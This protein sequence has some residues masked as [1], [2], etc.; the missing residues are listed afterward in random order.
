M[1][2]HNKTSLLHIFEA[3]PLVRFTWVTGVITLRWMLCG[4]LAGGFSSQMTAAAYG[5]APDSQPNQSLSR[6]QGTT[7]I[8][9]DKSEHL[10]AYASKQAD[11]KN[12]TASLDARKVANWVLASK[13]NS[14]MPFMIIDKKD[15]RV[16]VF[17]QDGQLRGAAP[18]L[19]GLSRGDVAVPGIG[20]RKL[21]TMLV[22]ERTTPAGRFV[23]S[24]DH[25]LHGEEILWIDYETAISL[26]RVHTNN[27]QEHRAER[28][29]TPTTLDNRISYGCINVPVV[30]YVS[31]VSLAFTGT[32]GIVYVLPETLSLGQVFNLY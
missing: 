17:N 10:G 25:N 21:S 32:N 24:L 27:A 2:I 20:K 19:L 3:M 7:T 30:F 1:T 31:V 5:D 8:S 4:L 29:S 9:T 18:A 6:Q 11:F 14:N 16:F 22:N 12:E 26:H 28:L 23:A 13:D 15:A